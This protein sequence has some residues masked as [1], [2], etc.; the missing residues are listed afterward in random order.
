[1]PGSWRAERLSF[2]G[3]R[4]YQLWAEHDF[5]PRPR[6]DVAADE[7][8]PTGPP[9]EPRSE[10]PQPKADTPP[11]VGPVAPRRPPDHEPPAPATGS[12]NLCDA[13]TDTDVLVRP[14]I[15]TGGRTRTANQIGVETLISVTD[16]GF[17]TT[18]EQSGDQRAICRLCQVA[19]SLAEIAALLGI[20]L[21]VA[22]VLVCDLADAGLLRVHA[23]TESTRPSK[24]LLERVLAGLRRI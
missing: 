8:A 4:S 24:E 14:Y 1:M 11:S 9:P 16:N 15:R 10:S 20:P 2:G 23:A 18:D 7:P 12:A 13:D 17:A 19:T 5:V 22:R 3:W 6:S 21:G